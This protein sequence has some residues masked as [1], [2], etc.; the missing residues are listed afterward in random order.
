LSPAPAVEKNRA[1]ILVSKIK[2]MRLFA[3]GLS[4]LLG[5][6]TARRIEKSDIHIKSGLDFIV[7]IEKARAADKA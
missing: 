3:L 5:L 1:I 2:V 4:I 6:V 7:R